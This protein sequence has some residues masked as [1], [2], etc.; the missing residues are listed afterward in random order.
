MRFVDR[1][2][3]ESPVLLPSSSDNP[4]GAARVWPVG[5]LV[6]AIADVLQ[7]RFNPVTVR[8][9]LSGFTRAASGHLYFNLKD[10]SGQLR[11]AMFRRS[12]QA[13]DFAPAEGDLVE[14]TGRLD[15]YGP[16][17]DLQLVAERMRRAGQGTL[18]EQFLRLKAQLE[19]EGCFDPARKRA[20]PAMPASIGVVTS[21]GAAAL[22]DVVSALARRVPHLPVVLYPAA[23]QGAQAPAELCAAL[24]QAY[25][26]HRASGESQV[27]LLVRGGGSLEDLWAFNDPALVRK[28]TEAPMPV[29]CG[30]GH[31]T[32]FTLCDFAADL[33]A[34]T[35]TAAAELCAPARDDLIA[36]LDAWQDRLRRLADTALDRR[37]Q[38]LDRLAQR[39]GRPSARLNDARARLQA[40]EHR[41]GRQLHLSAQAQRQRL[42]L[43]QRQLPLALQ[44]QHARQQDRLARSEQALALLDPKLVLQRGYA[45]LSDAD[46]R[47]ITRAAHTHP[48]QA[49]KAVLSDGEVG[50]TVNG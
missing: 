8:G 15:V 43:L 24:D 21:P 19:G 48:G 36:D 10:S 13:L 20:L 27:L 18:F 14:V 45:W 26:R 22:R 7:A 50:M 29:V 38:H 9:E 41:L 47:A 4:G 40:L 33:R 49:V 1:F 16:R 44:R 6:Q 25:A 46:G 39:L 31:E 12:A 3:L 42:D 35:P 32:D 2:P 37:A 30:V 5:A 17:G 23:V 28:L 11:C 34:P